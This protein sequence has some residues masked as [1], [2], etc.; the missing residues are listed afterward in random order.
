MHRSPLARRCGELTSSFPG[1]AASWSSRSGVL[2]LN[3]FAL[4]ELGLLRAFAGR[5][6]GAT[7]RSGSARFLPNVE[8][9]QDQ[10]LV[11]ASAFAAACVTPTLVL[12]RRGRATHGRG[13]GRECQLRPARLGHPT[14][15]G[16]ACCASSKRTGHSR[17]F[18]NAR[19]STSASCCR[20]PDSAEPPGGPQGAAARAR[21]P[22]QALEVRVQRFHDADVRQRNSPVIELQ[23]ARQI[24]RCRP[25]HPPSER[26]QRA[27]LPRCTA[28]SVRT[29]SAFAT[30]GA[31]PAT[32]SMSD[33][34]T[35]VQTPTPHS[36]SPPAPRT[37]GSA[38]R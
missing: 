12:A 25:N 16:R 23:Y 10:V 30:G 20:W 15:R 11:L 22:R 24:R 18:A 35:S 28:T 34:P 7:W 4:A 6:P 38:H 9:A 26:A 14:R 37:A 21:P 19:G 33:K 36:E 1:S 31:A 32:E 5:V 3:P 27:V 17:E 2:G 13:H 29:R 8:E